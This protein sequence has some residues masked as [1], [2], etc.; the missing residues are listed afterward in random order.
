MREQIWSSIDGKSWQ[1][2]MHEAYL[3]KI[4]LLEDECDEPYRL[5]IDSI[6][7]HQYY[8]SD[9]A[10]IDMA[11]ALAKMISQRF[12]EDLLKQAQEEVSA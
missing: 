11:K 5:E 12:H 1:I 8:L 6:D 4:T 10:D 3:C 7:G 2:M 9:V